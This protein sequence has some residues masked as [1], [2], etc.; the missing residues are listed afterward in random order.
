MALSRFDQ[1]SPLVAASYGADGMQSSRIGPEHELAAQYAAEDHQ[2]LKCLVDRTS[3]NT[4]EIERL[5]GLLSEHNDQLQKLLQ[6]V[7]GLVARGVVAD[8]PFE[9]DGIVGSSSVG[10]AP[11]EQTQ[12]TDWEPGGQR[13]PRSQTPARSKSVEQKA[14]DGSKERMLPPRSIKPDHRV[15][16]RRK[17]APGMRNTAGGRGH[18]RTKGGQTRKEKSPERTGSARDLSRTGA[19][20]YLVQGQRTDSG[21]GLNAYCKGLFN[22]I[23]QFQS[24]SAKKA[25]VKESARGR[26]KNRARTS[27]SAGKTK[28]SSRSKSARTKS[29]GSRP[30]SRGSSRS[31]RARTSRHSTRNSSRNSYPNKPYSSRPQSRA[32]SANSS[33]ASSRKGSRASSPIAPGN[34]SFKKTRKVVKSPKTKAKHQI[35][36][37]IVELLGPDR[38]GDGSVEL[39]ELSRI[40]QLLELPWQ[41]EQIRSVYSSMANGVGQV[42]RKS[43]V[44]FLTAE[45]VSEKLTGAQHITKSVLD[46][47][48]L[49]ARREQLVSSGE[50]LDQ[51]QTIYSPLFQ[52]DSDH[53]TREQF[54]GALR[55]T[56]SA[57]TNEQMG[58]LFDAID[59]DGDGYISSDEYT[60]LIELI[61]MGRINPTS[62]AEEICRSLQDPPDADSERTKFSARGW[63]DLLDSPGTA[64]QFQGWHGMLV[65]DKPLCL[66]KGKSTDSEKTLF[67]LSPLEPKTNHRRIVLIDSIEGNRVHIISPMVGWASLFTKSGK[68]LIKI[69]DGPNSDMAGTSVV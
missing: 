9:V 65:S 61:A 26:S 55:D 49:A 39:H 47:M 17:S 25:G 6:V 22:D 44:S 56:G 7:A 12:R 1:H 20:R 58:G 36:Q 52:G 4:G 30:S 41:P 23:K 45:A 63:G 14:R 59:K 2:T 66:R 29:A 21:K 42:T 27:R 46:E 11:Q 33:R 51:L 60:N 64:G 24:P 8:N 67:T 50:V 37:E 5:K 68:E 15:K 40:L 69:I 16:T 31:R 54:I 18:K 19:G 53:I 32:S 3:T 28:S 43:I 35:S 62:N 34:R 48:S 13:I 57:L 10:S 38:V